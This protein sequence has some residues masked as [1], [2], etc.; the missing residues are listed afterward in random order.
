MFTGIVTDIG[1]ITDIKNFDHVTK[2]RIGTSFETDDVMLGSSVA[3]N[4]CCLTVIDK[5][6]KQLSF[7]LSPET[8][9]KTNFL[10]QQLG[11]K[12]NLERSLKLG[13][14]LGGHIVTGHIDCLVEVIEIA[15]DFDNWV[16]KFKVPEKY[17][18]FVAE[19]GSVTVN[20]ISLTVNYVEDIFFKVN[21]IPHTMKNT[22]LNCIEVGSLLNFEVDILARYIERQLT[23]K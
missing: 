13:D 23:A 19:K 4:G 2:I 6:K 22:N 9:L 16:V 3:C 15:E 21:I 7:D 8:L 5:E 10:T 18:K 1:E 12:I 20:G 17:K 11:S 14:E